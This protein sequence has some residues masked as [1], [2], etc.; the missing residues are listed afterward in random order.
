[1]IKKKTLNKVGMA[2][3]DFNIINA[4]YDKSTASIMLNGENLKIFLLRSATEQ[5]YSLSPFLFLGS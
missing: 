3:T 5:E 2:R 4:V 1:M